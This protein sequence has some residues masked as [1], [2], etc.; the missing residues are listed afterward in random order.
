MSMVGCARREDSASFGLG[1]LSAI[2]LPLRVLGL[3]TLTGLVAGLVL[4]V[5][6]RGGGNG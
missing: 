4:G 2:S 6:A 3:H 5:E 1:A